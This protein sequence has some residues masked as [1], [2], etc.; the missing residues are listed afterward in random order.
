MKTFRKKYLPDG[1]SVERIDQ[2]NERLQF[3]RRMKFA[4]LDSEKQ[5][6][7]EAVSYWTLVLLQVHVRRALAL[8]DGGLDASKEKNT[9]IT[10][11]CARALYESSALIWHILET[12]MPFLEA[13]DFKGAGELLKKSLLPSRVYSEKGTISEP[14]KATNILTYIDRIDKV[15]PGFRDQYDDLSEIVHPNYPG[16]MELFSTVG[17][18]NVTHFH[19]GEPWK[20]MS[21]NFLIHGAYHFTM[22]A[23]GVITVYEKCLA[24]LEKQITAYSQLLP[25]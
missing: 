21:L 16:L 6:T 9:L 18:G 2:I 8:V 15:K 22:A 19:D 20:Q 1:F 10:Y 3:Y 17:E 7:I 12:L 5:T 4:V 11:F 25:E 13:D 24:L 23:P 14:F